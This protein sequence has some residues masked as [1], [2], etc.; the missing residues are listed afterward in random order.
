VV[1][2]KGYS[3]STYQSTKVIPNLRDIWVKSNSTRI[4]IKS[5]AIL[6]DLV[7][8]HTNT[9]PKCWVSAV[10]VHSLL[11]GFVRLGVFLL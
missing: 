2:Q 9:A 10:T 1:I 3:L 7:V 4:R 6:V 8:Q 5:V 11:I